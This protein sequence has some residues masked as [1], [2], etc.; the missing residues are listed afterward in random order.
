MT[1]AD[2]EPSWRDVIAVLGLLLLVVVGPVISVVA[3]VGAGLRD[4][5]H[6]RVACHRMVAPGLGAGP[7]RVT[8]LPA[9]SVSDWCG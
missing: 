9:T 5:L 6:R 7:P 3:N 4:L 8:W 2:L 1:R